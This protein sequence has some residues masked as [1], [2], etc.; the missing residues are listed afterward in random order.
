MTTRITR[1]KK[2]AIGLS[3]ALG[4]VGIAGAGFAVTNGASA[5]AATKQS[6]SASHN[7]TKAQQVRRLLLRHTV[8]AT[9]TVKTK[10]GYETLDLAR[11]TVGSISSTSITVDSPNGSTLT[12]SITQDTKFHNTTEG[13]LAN[14]SKVGVLSYEGVARQINAPKTAAN[15]SNA[16]S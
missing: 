10:S 9:I 14:G 1:V 5:S 12:A 4:S 11:G 7:P 3:V 8:D 13:A 16:A 6:A 15:P 2:A